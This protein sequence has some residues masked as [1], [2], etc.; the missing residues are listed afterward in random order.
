M[1]S[2]T[3]GQSLQTAKAQDGTSVLKPGVTDDVVNAVAANLSA[4]RDATAA[5][6]PPALNGNTFVVIEKPAATGNSLAATSLKHSLTAAMPTHHLPDDFAIGM[7][8]ENGTW[9]QHSP[10]SAKIQLATAAQTAI[11][12]DD[13]SDIAGDVWHHLQQLGDEIITGLKDTRVFLEDGISF[14]IS[15][16]GD[17]LQ[18]VLTI[19]EKV[20]EITLKTFVLV[21]K[22]LSWV[23]SLVGIDLPGVC[24]TCDLNRLLC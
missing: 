17:V 2:V 18:F 15:K 3:N 19:G 24:F 10:Q 20:L 14:V 23:L 4:L 9:I 21:F 11:S 12:W 1:K 6:Y 13:V 8:L 22:A 5:Q 16:A 7:K